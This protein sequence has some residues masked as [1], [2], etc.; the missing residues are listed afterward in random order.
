MIPATTRAAWDA[1][2]RRTEYRVELPAGDLLLRVDAYQP[3][4]DLRLREEAGVQAAWAIVTA[5]NP[6]SEDC[7][8]EENARLQEELAEIVSGLS[9]RAVSSVNRDPQAA[10]PDEPGFLLCDPPPGFA[11]ELGR[12]FRQNAILAGTVGQAPRLVWLE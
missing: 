12:R 11:E 1:A 9:L 6:G 3:C 8:K 4:D 10:W 2:Y 5:C 7:G